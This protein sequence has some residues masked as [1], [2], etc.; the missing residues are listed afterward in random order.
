MEEKLLDSRSVVGHSL[1][2][3][4]RV[5]VQV[6][7]LFQRKAP[8]QAV[9]VE[10]VLRRDYFSKNDIA[11]DL[12]HLLHEHPF[13]HQSPLSLEEFVRNFEGLDHCFAVVVF[14]VEE[15]LNDEDVHPGHHVEKVLVDE[16][17]LDDFL[18]LEHEA[19][20]L[21]FPVVQVNPLHED[22]PD[23]IVVKQGL[24]RSVQGEIRLFE[25]FVQMQAPEGDEA[26]FV[27]LNLE[28]H[29]E[30]FFLVE[31]GLEQVD[32]SLELEKGQVF[33]FQVRV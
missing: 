12:Q 11:R 22:Q 24:L 14:E 23:Q 1:F 10:E 2:L 32:I 16:R 6:E 18:G 26:G 31:G 20:G 7:L 21:R 5:D 33:H 30:D 25:D 15:R 19:Q 9:E 27:L 29:L 3:R 13:S 17:L 8:N 28:L 4:V